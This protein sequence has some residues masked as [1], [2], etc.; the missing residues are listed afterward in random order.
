MIEAA[1]GLVVASFV[2]RAR[3]VL[4][5]IYSMCYNSINFGSIIQ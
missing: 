5:E 1:I 4:T 3:H 2:E